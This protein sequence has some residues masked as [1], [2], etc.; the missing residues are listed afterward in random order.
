VKP[1]KRS[2]IE[3]QNQLMLRR[4]REFRVAADVVTDAWAAFDEVRAVAVIGSVAKALWKEIPRFSDFRRAGIEVWHECGDLDLA[5]WID[6]QE[7]LG[8]LRRSAALALRAAFERDAGTSVVSQ[9]LDVF[10]I[11]PG[12]D[13]YLG[14]LCSFNACP[15][16]KRDCLVPGCGA[17]PFNKV[18][19][20]F[21]PRADLL[22]P[23]AYAMLYERGVG[24]LR[25]ALDL[26]AVDAGH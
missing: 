17:I 12:S 7:R 8:S 19:A 22:E 16:G 5:L 11:E 14:R 20:E 1:V 13:R 18:I 23:A 21:K 25:S 24:R 4:Q 9:Q 15:K 6:S 26:P 10:L 3:Q 2:E